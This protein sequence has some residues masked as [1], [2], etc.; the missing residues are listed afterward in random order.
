MADP[1]LWLR[2]DLTRGSGVTCTLSRDALRAAAA[3]ARG[4]LETLDLTVC[5][6]IWAA[7]RAVAAANAGSLR[8]LHALHAHDWSATK[9]E[10]RALLSAAPGLQVLETDAVCSAAEA[11]P[12]LHNMPPWGPLRLRRLLIEVEDE[13][14][15]D[16][17]GEEEEEDEDSDGDTT[18]FLEAHLIAHPSL[19]ELELCCDLDAPLALNL[20]DAAV[21]AALTLGLTALEFDNCNLPPAAAP[22]LARLLRSGALTKLV[23]SNTPGAE[24]A[25]LDAPAAALLAA[26]L[27]ANRTL[28]HMEL[29]AVRLCDDVHDAVELLCALTGH[30]SL[31]SLNCSANRVSNAADASVIGA[32]LAALVATDAP[33]L[34]ELDVSDC[35]L[36][37]AGLGPLVDALPHN[38][39]LRELRVADNGMSAVFTAQRLLP[40]VRANTSLRMLEAYDFDGDGKMVADDRVEA[41]QLVRERNAARVAAEAAAAARGA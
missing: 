17:E 41:V 16:E 30:P 13:E 3:R 22:A 19:T 20:L 26:A 25:L 32:A 31:R 27:R 7:V 28:R 35:F 23:I 29:C 18:A 6:H 24:E 12:M 15:E 4:R 14:E 39:H 8:E 38:H 1:A 33:A 36:G 37:D 11:R 40:A 5:C 21:G 34:E 2:L 10:L 9:E